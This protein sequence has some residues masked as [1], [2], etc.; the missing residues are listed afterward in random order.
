ML[1][2]NSKNILFAK[3]TLI[4]I[5]RLEKHAPSMNNGQFYRLHDSTDGCHTLLVAHHKRILHFLVVG[6]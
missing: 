6:N 2:R 4:H 1:K 5:A 3:I